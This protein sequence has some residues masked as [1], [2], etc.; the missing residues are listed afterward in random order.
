[1]KDEHIFAIR[2]QLGIS[3][4]ALYK[5]SIEYKNE[6]DHIDE[7]FYLK[8]NN[9]EKVLAL[10]YMFSSGEEDEVVQK[11]R[12]QTRLTK[13]E[14]NSVKV[15]EN[16]KLLLLTALVYNEAFYAM[17][18]NCRGFI[19]AGLPIEKIEEDIITPNAKI[20]RFDSQNN[21]RRFFPI[22]SKEMK[23]VAAVVGCVLIFLL[24][25]LL[26]NLVLNRGTGL[27]F[28]NELTNSSLAAQGKLLVDD[29]I[30]S[31]SIRM[32]LLSP[33]I[34]TARAGMSEVTINKATI[35]YY[36]DYFTK[37]IQNDEK[38]AD[39]YI[40]RGVAYTL[41]ENFEA[42]IEDFN[43]AIKLDSG[44]YDAYFAKGILCWRQYQKHETT[45]SLEMAISALE[46]IPQNYKY[47]DNVDDYLYVLNDKFPIRIHPTQSY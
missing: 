41:D 39:L 24:G 18:V 33:S 17:A 46:L 35:D 1:M 19:S 22:A 3:L 47:K 10:L 44:N 36:I 30:F 12:E 8:G 16:Y 20:R 21:A 32:E 2:K 31:S 34:A 42:G 5:Y 6:I 13:I 45:A 23:V 7:I 40:N 28:G 26:S 4:A 15:L 9:K 27:Q 29:R 14:Y 43:E 11:Y 25:V 37:A 38:N